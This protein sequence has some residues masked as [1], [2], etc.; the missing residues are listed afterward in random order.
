MC[1]IHRVEDIDGIKTEI[2][3][4]ID[5]LTVAT[6]NSRIYSH[7]HPRVTRTVASLVKGLAAYLAE[8]ETDHLIVG[9]AE[10]FLF[11]DR[12]PLLGASLS[13]SKIIDALHEIGSGGIS[14]DAACHRDRLP[15]PAPDSRRTAARPRELRGGQS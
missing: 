12:R 15:Q 5:E 14:I 10:G 7:D 8:N 4:F 2:N 9:T 11:H 1:E 13:A 3:Q 6:T